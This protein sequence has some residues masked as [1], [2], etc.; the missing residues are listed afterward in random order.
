MRQ[1]VCRFGE[2]DFGSIL[3]RIV[4]VGGGGLLVVGVGICG[5]LG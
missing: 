3:G 4:L 1:C 5:V 2:L